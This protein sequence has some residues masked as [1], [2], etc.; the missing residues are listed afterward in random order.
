M[1]PNED[2]TGYDPD[3]A[4]RYV[5]DYESRY[6]TS[7]LSASVKRATD[8]IL[9]KQRDSGLMSKIRLIRSAICIS[10]MCLCVDGR[11]LRQMRFTL[12]LHPK[13]KRSTPL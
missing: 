11:R 12:I 4:R 6:D 10:S 8:A 1:Y 13:A 2:N 7:E 5:L 3:S 9:A